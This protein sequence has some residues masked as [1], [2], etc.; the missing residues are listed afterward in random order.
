MMANGQQLPNVGLPDFA[1][2]AATEVPPKATKK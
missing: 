1:E 2:A